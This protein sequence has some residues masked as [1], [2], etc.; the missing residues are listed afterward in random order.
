MDPVMDYIMGWSLPA[1]LCLI[2]GLLLMVYEM[3]TPGMGVP[4]LLGGICL[5]GAIVL[6]AD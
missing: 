6:R 5:L 3:F 4:A 1:L 2:A